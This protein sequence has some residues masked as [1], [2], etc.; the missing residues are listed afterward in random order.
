MNQQMAK[1][2][3]IVIIGAGPIGCYAGYL[4]AKSGHHVLIYE[5]HAEIGAPVQCTGLLTADFEQFQLPME[6]F[7]INVFDQV[8]VN[9]DTKRINLK[10]KEYLIDR[11]KFDNFL[12]DL[13]C[14]EGARIYPQ[15]SFLSRKD[16]NNL[17]IKDLKKGTEKL[18]SADIVIAADGPLSKT[19]KAYGLYHPERK[20]YVGVQ[21]LVKGNFKKNQYQT[22]FSEKKCPEL[23]AWVVP[24][25]T[26]SAR[27]GLAATKKAYFYFNRF[28]QENNFVPVK[29][30]SG[31]IPIFN[32]QQKLVKDNC[33][34]LGD[35]AGFVKATTLGGLI[36]GLKQAQILT[37][38]LNDDKDYD[39]ETG[40][41][42]KEMKLHLRLREI[43]NKFSD[44]DFDVL[45]G[46]VGQEKIQAV[47]EKHTRDNPWPIIV[48][49]LLKEPRL[50]YF[51]KYL[52]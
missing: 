19:A 17:I 26:Q 12:A 7:L 20:N 24:E 39:H 42:R 44:K 2:K 31:V 51:G 46:L 23:F 50:V 47:L 32:P 38:C 4:L 28:M 35:A 22:Y 18:V 48:K 41:L 15:H 3:N 34:L 40:S 6:N 5:E 37:N 8:E 49:S 1:K 33:Y 16:E 29:V 43:L 36:P 21:A 52:F 11:G 10:Q 45:L 30:Q 14:K 13:A 25:S 9:S 27:V